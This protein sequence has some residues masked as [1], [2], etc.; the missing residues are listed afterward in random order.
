MIQPISLKTPEERGLDV[1]GLLSRYTI[2]EDIYGEYR[3]LIIDRW[4][5]M[6]QPNNI[7]LYIILS[8]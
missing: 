3:V 4:I 5:R 7:E 6:N 1:L 2:D 8:S